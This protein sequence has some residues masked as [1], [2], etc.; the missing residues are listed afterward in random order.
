LKLRVQW[1]GAAVTLSFDAKRN[2]GYEIL[3]RDDLGPGDWAVLHDY[4]DGTEE[5][6]SMSVPTSNDTRFY[7][8][9]LK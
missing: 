3:V 2:R 9:R 6:K 7:S 4:T 1:D 8:V 5:V